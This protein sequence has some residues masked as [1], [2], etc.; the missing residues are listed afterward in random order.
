M[1]IEY[2][3]FSSSSVAFLFIYFF[4]LA[5]VDKSFYFI[6]LGSLS[7]RVIFAGLKYQ[8]DHRCH[9]DVTR[10][11]IFAGKIKITIC[12]WWFICWIC[13]SSLFLFMILPRF[14]IRITN[15]SRWVDM[16]LEL[17]LLVIHCSWVSEAYWLGVNP[18]WRGSYND[19]CCWVF[20]I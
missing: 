7:F 12:F 18:C 13:D 3:R 9:G 2:L 10:I 5:F 17:L 14:F 16:Y 4:L 1:F 6:E 8:R 20:K 19:W 15:F 11:F